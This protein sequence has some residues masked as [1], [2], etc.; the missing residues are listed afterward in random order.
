MRPISAKY[1]KNLCRPPYIANKH[2]LH[3]LCIILTQ[4]YEMHAEIDIKVSVKHDKLGSHQT[5]HT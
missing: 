4:M 1:N 2:E 5:P 3:R